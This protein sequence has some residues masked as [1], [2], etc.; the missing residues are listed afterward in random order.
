MSKNDFFLLLPAS[1][2]VVAYKGPSLQ[3]MTVL[4]EGEINRNKRNVT[5]EF[6]LICKKV[7]IQVIKH[8]KECSQLQGSRPRGCLEK[9]KKIPN[10][11]INAG[12]CKKKRISF[13]LCVYLFMCVVVCVCVCVARVACVCLFVCVFVCCVCLC[14][15][16]CCVFVCALVFVCT[17]VS[18]TEAE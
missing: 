5:L 3:E 7:S 13:S 9:L 15:S 6:P 1:Y 17:R 11:Y 12:C 16:V 14:A 10:P 4:P 8:I 18:V 2:D